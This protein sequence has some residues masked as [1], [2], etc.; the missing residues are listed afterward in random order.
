V[1][2]DLM[3]DVSGFQLLHYRDLRYPLYVF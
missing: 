3:S 1:L 2:N